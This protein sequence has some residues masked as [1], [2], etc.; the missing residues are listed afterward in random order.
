MFKHLTKFY[1]NIPLVGESYEI[2]KKNVIYSLMGNILKPNLIHKGTAVLDTRVNLGIPI[3][4][5][6]G[7][8]AI[9]MIIR[10]TQNALGRSFVEPTSL[11][12]EQL[13]GKVIVIR[14][15]NGNIIEIVKNKGHLS[16]DYILFEE[17]IELFRAKEHQETRNYLNV[18]LDTIGNNEIT[19]RNVD[20]SQEDMLR[21]TPTCTICFLFH[22]VTLTSDILERGLLRR[23]FICYV[24]PSDEERL[25]ALKMSLEDSNWYSSFEEWIHFLK[26]LENKKFNWKL[27]S[28]TCY[29][30][31]K[32][33]YKLIQDGNEYS[34]KG[35]EVTQYFWFTLRD[36][37]IKLSCILAGSLG[38]EDIDENIVKEAYLDMKEFWLSQLTYIE[39]HIAFPQP[40]IT[41]TRREM[42]YKTMISF[43]AEKGALSEETSN[44][45]IDEF[46]NTMANHLSLGKGMARYYYLQL[47]KEGIISKRKYKHSSKVWLNKVDKKEV[48]FIEEL[49]QK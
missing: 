44:I 38:R 27:D 11:H 10:K 12:P 20:V 37:I 29:S 3:K 21:Y 24:N 34:E 13:V 15:N 45:S 48:P 17:A 14:D 31:A 8:K 16:A 2:V 49:W 30:I 40:S 26:D 4:S 22:P 9:E 32:Y 28:N 19:K 1:D 42:I 33:T 43:L 5:G 36:R 46:I 18:A 7:K 35:R 47:V 6:M 41:A 39:N 25:K 23:L